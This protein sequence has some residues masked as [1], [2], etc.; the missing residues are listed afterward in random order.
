MLGLCLGTGIPNHA[1]TDINASEFALWIGDCR[2]NQ[3]S[4]WPTPHVEHTPEQSS[5]GLLGEGA[6]HYLREM[7]I[8]NHETDHLRVT[9]G[10]S[11]DIRAWIILSSWINGFRHS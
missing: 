2:F 7:L 3:P 5:I 11:H 4:T 1:P 8:L 9:I 10:I 6:A